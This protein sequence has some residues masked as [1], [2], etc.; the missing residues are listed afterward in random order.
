PTVAPNSG[1]YP[2]VL[3]LT[4]G[5]M[6]SEPES[7]DD[8]AAKLAQLMDDAGEANRLGQAGAQGVAEHYNIAQAADGMTAAFQDVVAAPC[9]ETTD[10]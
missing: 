5:G 9:K 6:L 2:E 4:R 10:A 3:G 1:V 8:L 7:A